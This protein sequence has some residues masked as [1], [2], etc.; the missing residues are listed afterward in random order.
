MGGQRRMDRKEKAIIEINSK[1]GKSLKVTEI[2]REHLEERF[3]A[4]RQ[5]FE[6]GNLNPTEEQ[7]KIYRK[8]PG[9]S[10]KPYSF[11]S[12]ESRCLEIIQ[13]YKD[14]GLAKKASK[15]QKILKQITE[16]RKRTFSRHDI[17]LNDIYHKIQ[18]YHW[19]YSEKTKD[20]TMGPFF[21]HERDKLYYERKMRR[22]M[23]EYKDFMQL[24]FIRDREGCLKQACIGEEW[25][26]PIL[27]ELM[28]AIENAYYLGILRKTN[29]KDFVI[30][31]K[32]TKEKYNEIYSKLRK[33]DREKH[34][35]R[36]K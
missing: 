20:S 18:C 24:A 30:P 25:R 6:D 27:E 11:D 3:D 28:E 31:H 9:W 16:N 4:Y 23:K 26:I 34:H 33:K 2:M 29:A 35:W 36:Y 1:E 13:Y 5:L 10:H 8:K 12:A 22:P 17:I 21:W 15:F 14:C 19:P 32:R 7:L